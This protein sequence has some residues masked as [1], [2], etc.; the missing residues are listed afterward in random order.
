MA[1]VLTCNNGPPSGDPPQS[2]PLAAGHFRNGVAEWV[3]SWQVPLEVKGDIAYDG[4]TAGKVLTQ[5]RFAGSVKIMSSCAQDR[6]SYH[7]IPPSFAAPRD[8]TLGFSGI[9]HHWVHSI[10]LVQLAHLRLVPLCMYM[11]PPCLAPLGV[12]LI[13][14]SQHRAGTDS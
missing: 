11:T 13:P 2:T 14:R 10:A 4:D 5:R 9:P 6:W 7:T 3:L 1:S 12:P 8:A